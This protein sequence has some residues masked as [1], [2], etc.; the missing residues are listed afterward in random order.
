MKEMAVATFGQQLLISFIGRKDTNRRV[1]PST[2]VSVPFPFPFEEKGLE[3]VKAF[4]RLELR[5]R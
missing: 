1:T 4:Q 2:L 3:T 5:K